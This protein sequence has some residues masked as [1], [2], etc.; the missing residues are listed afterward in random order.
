MNI[1][2]VTDIRSGHIDE[3]LARTLGGESIESEIQLILNTDFVNDI[4]F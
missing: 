1:S 3:N 2:I 4:L